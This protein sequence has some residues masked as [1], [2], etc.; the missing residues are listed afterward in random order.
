MSRA[1]DILP[2][3]DFKEYEFYQEWKTESKN[4]G[5]IK[6]E[7]KNNQ[8]IARDLDGNRVGAWFSNKQYGYVHN[9]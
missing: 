5:A 1:S 9:S 8:E 7:V 2:F 4:E 3:L 6:F